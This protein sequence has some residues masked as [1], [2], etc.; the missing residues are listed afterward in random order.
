MKRRRTTFL[1]VLVTA[2]AIIAA[3]ALL[4]TTIGSQHFAFADKGGNGKGNGAGNGKGG[5]N[6]NAKGNG[7][8]NGKGNGDAKGN[9]NGNGNENGNGNGNGNGKAK[10]QD[11]DDAAGA[12]QSDDAGAEQPGNA[13]PDQ[14]MPGGHD[15]IVRSEVVVADA[16]ASLSAFAVSQGFAIVRTESLDALGLHVTRLQA[17]EGLSAVQARDVI[18]QRF[19]EAIVD[20]NHLYEPQTSLSLPAAD[21]AV[22]AVRWNAK[23][24]ECGIAARIGLIDTE[25][26]WALPI[27]NGA[28]RQAANFLAEG[29]GAA[30]PQHGTGIATL[31]VGQEGFGLLPGAEL[32][33]AA[34]F[35]LDG[36]GA[37]VASATSFAS[38]LNW[39]LT[40]KV[41]TINVSLSGP[42]DRLME[43]A[44]KR[45]QQ[46]GVELVAAVGNDGTSDVP[47]FP[48]AYAGVIGVTAVDQAGRVFSDANRG[49]FVALAAP[50]VNLLIPGQPSAGGASDRLVTGTSF[51][52]PYVTAALA[53]YGNDPT[54]MFADAVDLGTPGPD[55]VFGRGLVQGPNACISAAS[56]E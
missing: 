8:A 11:A 37:P 22:K 13:V 50:G 28:H 23:L 34:I 2:V 51:A 4:S 32:Y 54:Q 43:L 40:N 30:P 56:A 10:G 48:A 36:D 35:G 26:D 5:G 15:R 16:S 47:R 55:P 31:L 1:S 53:S 14:R 25:V 45:A 6:G 17:P 9:G 20:F 3:A 44:V 19:P 12:E 7:N 21:Y 39:L 46:R 38:A 52:A 49:S 29:T 27:L 24:R 41:A 18:T 33:S 42:P